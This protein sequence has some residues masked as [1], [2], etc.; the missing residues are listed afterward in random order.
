LLPHPFWMRFAPHALGRSDRQQVFRDGRE[1]FD[2][3]LDSALDPADPD[4]VTLS[5]LAARAREQAVMLAALGDDESA[6]TL[7]AGLDRVPTESQL[8]GSIKDM[9][10]ERTSTSQ[11]MALLQ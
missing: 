9:L 7:V 2:R 8:A 10:S 11:W 1:A 4:P 6:A 3:V 5:V